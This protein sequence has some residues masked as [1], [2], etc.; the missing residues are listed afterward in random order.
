MDHLPVSFS[1]SLGIVDIP[2][3]RLEEWVNE[4][5]PGEGFI[6][7]TRSVGV[8]LFFKPDNEGLNLQQGGFFG[9]H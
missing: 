1:I 6:V 4:I 9:G 8:H 2:A 7:F 3:E 5:T